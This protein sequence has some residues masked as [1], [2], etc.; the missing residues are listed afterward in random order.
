MWG[1]WWLVFIPCV[2]V[3]VIVYSLDVAWIRAEMRKPDWDG[4]PDMDIVFSIGLLVRLVLVNVILLLI[5]APICHVIVRRFGW[6]RSSNGR[7]GH[8]IQVD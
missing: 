6:C 4:T 3:S 8:G 2:V 7:T 5:V 1:R